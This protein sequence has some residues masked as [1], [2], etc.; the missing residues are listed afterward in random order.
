KYEGKL[1]MLADLSENKVSQNPRLNIHMQPSSIIFNDTTWHISK[2]KIVIDTSSV[3]VDSFTISNQNQLFLVSGGIS[4]DPDE[5]LKFMFNDLDLAT[6]NIFTR[7]AR[8]E[9]NGR[10]TGNASLKNPLNNPLFLADLDIKS[11]FVNGEDFGDGEIKAFW[12]NEDKRIHMLAESKKGTAEILRTEG[13]FY[14]ETKK[15]DFGITFDKI[16]LSTFSPY[17]D[18]LI[19]DLKG[20]GS[21]NLKLT[22]TTSQPDLNGKVNL[23]KTSFVVNYLQTRYYFTNDVDISHNNVVIKNFEVYDERGNKTLAEGSVDTKYFKDINLNIN[24]QT[25]NFNF[26]NTTER[27]NQM[28]YGRIFASGFIKIS[29]PPDNLQMDINA[30][31]EKNSVFFIPLYGSEEV[32]ENDFIKFVNTSGNESR[33][34]EKEQNRYEVNLKGLSLNFNLD[35][36]NDAEVQLIF[37]PKV[38]DILRG[39]GNGNLKININTLGKFEIFGDISIESGD[40]LFTLQNVINKK[41]EV[42]PGG[43]ITWNGDPEDANIDV[44]AV[45]ALRTPVSPLDPTLFEGTS[46]KRIPVECVIQMTGKLMNPT[47]KPDIVLPTADQET[48]R[49]VKNSTSTEEEL[50]KQFLSLLVVNS[51]YSNQQSYGGFAGTGAATT[52]FASAGV[53]ASELLN[54]QLNH[55]LSQIS[56]DLDIGFN[57]RPGSEIS[58]DEYE[59]ALSTQIL[60]DRVT[61]NGNVDVGGNQTTQTTSTTNTNN[62]VGDFDID[63]KITENGKVHL[64][65]FN[66]ANDN[67][68]FQTSPYTQGVGVF[69]RE[70]FN[71]LGGLLRRYR[72]AIVELFTS[73]KKKKQEKEMKESIESRNETLP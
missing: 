37:D 32:N 5:T 70:D 22:G 2:S 72:D 4:T 41:F 35:V 66:R 29:G 13:D 50:M 12:N 6:L 38:G 58:S 55:W 9:F 33:E 1:N 56:K 27:D 31:S 11:L 43:R 67:L 61:I 30:R 15:L 28:F 54:N 40:Y 39:R 48:R 47:I 64:K 62:I 20:L 53:A 63:V 26:L 65:A 21:G 3:K 59:V 57:Y 71:S 68:L 49:I 16:R 45:Y 14:P 19:S 44:E 23:F 8:L 34:K 7:R 69:F 17:T 60:N 46:S 18:F 52:T 24:L 25:T 36:T 10:M 51:F 42:E 73:D